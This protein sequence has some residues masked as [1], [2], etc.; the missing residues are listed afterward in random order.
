MILL[1]PIVAALLPLE[2]PESLRAI[3]KD[4]SQEIKV[5][6]LKAHVYR[7]ASPEFLGRR[8]PGAARTAKH[9]AEMFKT[10]GLQPAF[11]KSYF[12]PIPNYLRKKKD[13]LAKTFMGKNVGAVLPG[14]DPKFKDEWIVLSAH[15]DHLGKRGDTLFPGA[16]DNASGVA[17]LLEVAE[18]LAL[19]KER[20]KRT[21]V[22]VSFDLEEVGLLGSQHF[23]R[24]PPR[25]IKKLKFF[26][27]ADM[28]GRSMANVMDEYVF[29]LGSESAKRLRHLIN[30]VSPAKGLKIGR[31]GTDIIGT[32]SDYGPFRDRKIPFLFFST[33]QHSDYHQP[34]DLPDR[35]DYHRL[36]KISSWIGKLT[37]RLAN[38]T[39]VPVWNPK[40]DLKD[41]E[42]VKT[43]HT[44]LRR[45]LDNSDAFPLTK[46][47]RKSVERIAA[48]LAGILK[49]GKITTA[50]RTRLVWTS[51]LLLITVFR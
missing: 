7:L 3:E 30:K 23:A 6:E 41:M 9:I 10:I 38:D 21:I 2:L 34:S 45:A 42:E 13:K 31:M 18:R 24:N 17:M 46:S 33:G 32:R 26:A 48:D 11:G 37:L 12:Q 40:P 22:F 35:I 25:D 19:S 15:F 47:R 49:R 29:V 20:P 28:L 44:L 36:Q 1:L 14:S 8:G 5:N 39:E 4:K 43:I 16:D 50:E 51:R 27:T